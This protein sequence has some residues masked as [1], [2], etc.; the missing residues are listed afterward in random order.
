MAVKAVAER[1]TQILAAGEK[2]FN[3]KGYLA[4]SVRDLADAVGMEA[5][6]LYS[7]YKS[8]EDILWTIADRCANEFFESVKPIANSKLHTQKKLTDMIVA[9][10]GVIT[11]NID[12]SAVFFREWRHIGEPRRSEYAMLRNEYESIFKEVVRQGIQENLFKNYDEGFSTRTI[13]SALN[14]THTWYRADGELSSEE[15]GQHLA[16][17]LL[18]GLVRTV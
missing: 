8:K 15:I 1:K 12:A 3:E 18:N 4:T 17:I 5:A 7:H 11:R 6:S 9:H 16:G 2:L 10:V 14:W 13:M